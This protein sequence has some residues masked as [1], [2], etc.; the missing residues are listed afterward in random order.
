MIE[1]K[2]IGYFGG[3]RGETEFADILDKHISKLKADGWSVLLENDKYDEEQSELLKKPT[4]E[5][6]ILLI[7]IT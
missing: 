4:F 5:N 6:R 7:K 2:T 1:F 3:I